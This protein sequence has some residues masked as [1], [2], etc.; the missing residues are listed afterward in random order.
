MPLPRVL[1]KVEVGDEPP[2]EFSFDV[3]FQIGRAD[4]IDVCIKNEYV[5]RRHVQVAEEDGHWCV[6]DLNSSNGMYL[7]G[8]AVGAVPLP[9][10]LPFAWAWPG[11]CCIS[12]LKFP[13]HHRHLLQRCR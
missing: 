11:R 4:G 1:L 2:L 3:P 8:Q 10:P 6:R 13:H 7:D 12:P 9:S 5:S